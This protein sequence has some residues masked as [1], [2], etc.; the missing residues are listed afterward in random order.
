M[1]QTHQGHEP[2]HY[3]L[4]VRG[5]HGSTRGS[6]LAVVPVL[7]TPPR[8]RSVLHRHNYKSGVSRQGDS[9]KGCPAK[10]NPI[11]TSA[12]TLATQAY[13]PGHSTA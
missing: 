2:F 4:V 3:S 1:K 5:S 10:G 7:L 8:V 9:Y 12:H 6:A 13:P 11:N